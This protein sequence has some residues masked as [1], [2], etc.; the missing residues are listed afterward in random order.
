[1]DTTSFQLSD[2]EIESKGKKWRQSFAWNIVQE[3]L[4]EK[5]SVFRNPNMDQE[6]NMSHP[7]FI[8][9]FFRIY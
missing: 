9:F 5:L 8:V 1:M 4:I 7:V 2:E 3:N 6:V